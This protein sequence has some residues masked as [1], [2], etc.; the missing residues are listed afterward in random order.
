MS[1]FRHAVRLTSFRF[2]QRATRLF[3]G[4][5]IVILC[6]IGYLG[7]PTLALAERLA[8]TGILVIG[9]YTLQSFASS[10]L[11]RAVIP[12]GPVPLCYHTAS[13][14]LSAPLVA[15]FVWLVLDGLAGRQF[16]GQLGWPVAILFVAL[17]CICVTALELNLYPRL[18]PDWGL[19]TPMRRG[20]AAPTREETGS[21]LRFVSIGGQRFRADRLRTVRSRDHYLEVEVEGGGVTLVHGRMRD[22]ARDVPAEYGRQVHRSWWVSYGHVSAVEGGDNRKRIVLVDGRT[23]PVGPSY[24]AAL[25]RSLPI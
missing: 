24:L 7:D 18:F 19:F 8:L 4:P 22:V 21:G 9:C 14:V 13:V 11:G 5:S 12:K 17:V 6:V 16:V 25:S 2:R 23:V 20:G 15:V 1:A 10:L 3:I